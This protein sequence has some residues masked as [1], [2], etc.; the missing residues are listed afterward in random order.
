MQVDYIIVGQGLAGSALA[1]RLMELKKKILVIDQPARNTSSQIAA[2]LFN[3]ITGRKMVK[4]W[5]ADKLFP[6]LHA[7]YRAVE[8]GVN[9]FA[10]QMR[11]ALVLSVQGKVNEAIAFLSNGAA[12]AV[13][14]PGKILKRG[15][16]TVWR[17]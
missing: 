6:A 12:E 9:Y 4:T 14:A 16:E 2:G 15:D 3:P 17:I 5:L 7:H 11:S 10:A 8:G 1:V 13:G